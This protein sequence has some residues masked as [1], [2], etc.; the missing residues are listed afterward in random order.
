MR[1]PDRCGFTSPDR[2]GAVER[3]TMIDDDHAL[4]EELA[5]EAG[6]WLPGW[7]GA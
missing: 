2:L 3:S 7:T 6:R 1:S 5:V 4:A